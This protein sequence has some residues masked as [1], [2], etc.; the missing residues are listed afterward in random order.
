[1]S[2]EEDAVQAIV[3]DD[4]FELKMGVLLMASLHLRD[5]SNNDNNMALLRITNHISGCINA[6]THLEGLQKSIPCV[7]VG[8]WAR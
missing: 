4:A 8:L 6:V 3:A 5:M 2:L 1:M 7:H